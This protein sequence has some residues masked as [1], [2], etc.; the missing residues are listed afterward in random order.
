MSKVCFL[1]AIDSPRSQELEAAIG[2]IFTTMA[3]GDTNTG[4]CN[5]NAPPAAM[6]E[7]CELA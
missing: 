2:M 5:I 4:L 1:T 3:G 6:A 7:L